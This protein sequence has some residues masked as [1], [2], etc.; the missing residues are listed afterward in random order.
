MKTCDMPLPELFKAKGSVHTNEVEL[1]MPKI[2]EV[3]VK[4]LPRE[5]RHSHRTRKV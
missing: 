1:K 5:V 3:K 2:N 4:R